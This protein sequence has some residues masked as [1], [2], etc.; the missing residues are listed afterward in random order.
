MANAE[1]PNL[2]ADWRERQA[3]INRLNDLGALNL[4]R[5]ILAD[6]APQSFHFAIGRIMERLREENSVLALAAEHTVPHIAWATRN[7]MELRVWTRFVYQSQ[8]NLNRFV[9]DLAPIGASTMRAQLRLV[10]DLADK[11]PN[12]IRPTGD[13]YKVSVRA[14]TGLPNRLEL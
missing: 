3:E 4:I 9:N 6:G 5:E 8:A 7:I 14:S 10:N 12:P 11:V 2:P 13:Q 1:I